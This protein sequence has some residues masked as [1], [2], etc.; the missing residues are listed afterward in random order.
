MKYNI[1]TLPNG[2]FYD[3]ITARDHANEIVKLK[4]INFIKLISIPLALSNDHSIII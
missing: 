4:E 3:I 2:R 1:S